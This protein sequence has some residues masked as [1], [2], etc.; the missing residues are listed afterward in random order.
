MLLRSTVLGFY[1]VTLCF[2]TEKYQN[3][4]SLP[5]FGYDCTRLSTVL[6]NVQLHLFYNRSISL[7]VQQTWV[8]IHT[9]AFVYKLF[10]SARLH[11]LHP[12]EKF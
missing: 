8:L 10:F 5:S 1:T 2:A 3:M 4:N 11:D 7:P 9:S 12:D 6:A